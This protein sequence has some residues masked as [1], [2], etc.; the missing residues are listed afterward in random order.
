MVE[1][2]KT[3]INI[4]DL[5]MVMKVLVFSDAHASIE[6]LDRVERLAKRKKPDLIVCAGDWTL[7]GEGMEEM[8]FL[9]NELPQKVLVIH[10]N[11][12]EGEELEGV[13]K[14]YSNLIYKHKDIYRQDG[15]A[16][17]CYGGGGF[18]RRDDEFV[19]WSEKAIKKVKDEKIVLVTH[20]PPANT[21]C[22]ELW[23]GTHCGSEDYKEFVDKHR[24]A[25]VLCGHIHES[26]VNYK[27]KGTR[28]V[29][30]GPYGVII[31]I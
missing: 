26:Q 2:G 1:W 19:K 31:E 25:A 17:L 5:E 27:K 28:F 16:F 21:R 15:V 29:N 20:A 11:H 7:F 13:F 24:P 8:L 30:P 4:I 22:D 14:E 6:A 18:S 23:G 12:E 10:G 9:M 3:F